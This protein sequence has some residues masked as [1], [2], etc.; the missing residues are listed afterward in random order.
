MY[1]LTTIRL[2]TDG[3]TDYSIMPIADHNACSRT[4]G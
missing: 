1:R 3:Q 4:I 2:Q